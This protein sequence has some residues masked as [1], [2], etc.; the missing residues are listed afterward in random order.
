VD[1][2]TATAL[3][4]LRRIAFLRER[5]LE[6]TYRVKAFRGAAA[7]L[8]GLPDGEVRRRIAQG[9]LQELADVGST[10]ATVIAEA[11]AGGVPSYL[12]EL[13][14]RVGGPVATG[15]E[16]LLGALRGD[17]HTHSEWSDGG[18]P[19]LEMA[20]TARD[21]GH[22]YAA[23]TDHSPRLTVAHGL[24]P[25]RLRDQLAVVAAV[26]AQLAPFR[27]LSGIECDIN[28]DGTLDQTPELLGELDVVVAPPCI[29]I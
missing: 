27:L 10:T 13:E 2:A 23:L 15:G 16:E 29:P 28:P 11:V 21:L 12:A 8:E 19:I 25:E 22:E 9:T 6:S 26:G 17:L 18:S 20:E 5:A 24:T 3:V 1:D 4:A 7:T 14:A